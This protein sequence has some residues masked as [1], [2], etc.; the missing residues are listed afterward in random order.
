MPPSPGRWTSTPTT[1]ARVRREYV[2]QRAG[3]GAGRAS[4]RTACTRASSTGRPRP[5]CRPGLRAPPAGR[6]RWT[7]RLLADELV[8]LEVVDAVSHETVR[9]TLTANELKPWLREQ[10]C[11]PPEANAEFVWHMEDVLDVYTRP[12][13]SRRPVSAWT[14]PAGNS[15]PRCARRCRRCPGRPAR[16]DPE[17]ARD[18]VANLFLV[19]EPLRGWRQV[20]VSDQRTRI[21]WAHCIK[22]L[23]DVHYPDAE[24]SCW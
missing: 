2:E 12:L 3:G 18:G 19:S 16:H 20:R 21:D 17:Y 7:L 5:T 23:V 24:G 9:R 22:D 8:R 13:R 14:R 15:W 4:A 11:I 10:W 1:V 6:E